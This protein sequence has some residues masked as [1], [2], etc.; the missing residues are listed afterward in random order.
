M[1][2]RLAQGAHRVIRF[3]NGGGWLLAAL[4]LLVLAGGIVLL[5]LDATGTIAPLNYSLF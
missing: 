4:L 3:W 2:R 1:R 5:A